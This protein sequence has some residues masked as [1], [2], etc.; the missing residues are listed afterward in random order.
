[1]KIKPI[2][3]RTVFAGLIAVG[4]GAS[5]AMSAHDL[6][7][8]G[9]DLTPVGA[10]KAGSK[11]GG[12]PAWDGG[13]AARPAGIEAGAVYADPFAGDKPLYTITSANLQQY[14]GKL[15]PGQIE[16]LKRMPGYKLVVYPSH[17]TA[18]LPQQEYETIKAEAAKATLAEGGNGI[19]NVKS[20]TVPFPM[21]K[22]GVEVMW[23]H[24][25]RHRGGSLSRNS[26][27]FPVQTNGAFT[28]VV[29]IENF[30][31]ASA[32]KS[33]EPNRLF[34]YLQTDTAPSS[35]AGTALLIHET[36]DQVKEPRLVWTYNPGSRRV[37]R[38]PE[39]SYDSPGF[40]T[41]GLSTSDDY[42]G[43]NGAPDRY[44]WKL[45]GKK[46]MII[47]YNNYRLLGKDVKPGDIVKPGHLNQ[48]LV[49]YEPHRVWVVEATLKAG[50]RH[51][52]GKRV[53][54]VD[55]DS[56]QIA[57]ADAFDGRGDLWRVHEM[58]GVQFYDGPAFWFA[59]DVQYD[60]QARRYLVSGLV[61]AAKPVK[62]GVKFDT[63]AFS[64]EAMR[65]FAN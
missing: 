21:P 41:D 9:K 42:D 14:Q 17:R 36:L 54:Y 19:L 45:V 58:H 53:F 4:G 50:K 3:S 11:D 61:N 25:S 56:W 7:R 65:R 30:A 12:I 27:L 46:E 33:A 59:C 57:H 51:V 20:T 16:M 24:M 18:A 31:L 60:L 62:F 15:A 44:D 35:Q 1:M 8:L 28:P 29:R 34:Y 64:T 23:N 55:E 39:V 5:A 32:L 38:A 63:S 22:S 37:M 48:D 47:S 26:S 40:G 10:E 13:L 49:R 43:F 2:F 52:Y 6:E